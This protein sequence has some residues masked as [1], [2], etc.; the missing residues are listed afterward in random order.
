MKLTKQQIEFRKRLES[1]KLSN[2]DDL[3]DI[4]S[5]HNSVDEYWAQSASQSYCDSIESGNFKEVVL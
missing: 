2:D 5:G 3:S 1:T 4:L